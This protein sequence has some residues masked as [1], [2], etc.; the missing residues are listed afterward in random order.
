MPTTA[1]GTPY[2]V[3]SSTVSGAGTVYRGVP[4]ALTTAPL[5]V[6]LYCHGAGGGANQFATLSA[7]AGL[8]DWLIDNGW[9]WIE[10]T[11]GGSQPWGNPA[12]QDA[13]DAA[14]AYADSIIDITDVVVL[15]RSMGGAV[16]ARLY[17]D[18]RASDPRWV[19]FICNSGVQDLAWAY[20]CDGGR[21]TAAFDNAWG[22][23][24]K[25]EF[26]TA[27]A[28]LNPVD[29]PETVWAGASVLQLVGTAD[30][31]VPAEHNGLA[32]RAMYAGQ[33]A[34]DQLDTKTG[35]DHSS[36]NGSYGQVDAMAAFLFTVIG[37]TPP[38]PAPKVIYRSLGRY[39]RIE[40][41]LHLVR[42]AP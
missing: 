34:I 17:L 14:F 31:I 42:P 23:S 40:G 3:T 41:R 37:G 27:V 29:G 10:G 9:A 36:S 12:S 11:G 16:G 4:D 7:W 20:D 5:P 8:R 30:D 15:G 24:S 13:Y 19:G 22:V 25:P 35:G 28:E 18:H 6:V 33:P 38:A 26:L 21:W 1:N 32:M 39:I 2:T